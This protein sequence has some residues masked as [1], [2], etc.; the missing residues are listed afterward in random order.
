M[1]RLYAED[2]VTLG[3]DPVR[4]EIVG[5][6][7]LPFLVGSGLLLEL[8]LLGAVDVPPGR[9][10]TY[11]PPIRVIGSAGHDPLLAHS[12]EWLASRERCAFDAI[13]PLG[14][15]LRRDLMER[16]ERRSLVRPAPR[17]RWRRRTSWLAVHP[18][19]ARDARRHLARLLEVPAERLA[20]ADATWVALVD[21][22]HGVVHLLHP[23]PPARS[24]LERRVR[25]VGVRVRWGDLEETAPAR[26]VRAAQ[27][28][29]YKPTLS[30]GG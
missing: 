23:D 18:D 6:P 24:S 5:D 13:V 22:A 1:E 15:E 3:I 14:W 17:V 28:V 2:L 11:A 16:L 8:A 30:G 7:F 27:N 9:A 26:V 4:H 12:L 21:T 19:V 20:P 29:V 10:D 25:D